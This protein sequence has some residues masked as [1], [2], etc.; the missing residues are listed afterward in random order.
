MVRLLLVEDNKGIAG[1]VRS[2]LSEFGFAVDLAGS[3]REFKEY[4]RATDYDVIVL[5]LGLPDGDGITVLR[6]F[7]G[8]SNRAA[9]LILTARNDVE[10]RIEGLR[11]GAD[12]YLG[13][14]FSLEELKARV[15]ALSRRPRQF[16]NDSLTYGNV[17]FDRRT[18]NVTVDS[19][20]VPLSRAESDLLEQLLLSP[21]TT[22]TREALENALFSWDREF[23]DNA[24]QLQVHRL[25]KTLALAGADIFVETL[26]GVG[27][28]LRGA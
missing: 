3:L 25:R 18:R 15:L 11:Q 10:S 20:L 17:A 2:A 19:L 23:S 16:I 4:A 7:R 14:P 9:I 24:L 5:D 6:E 22:C 26:R 28:R 13:K 27:Y 1:P 12:D 8:N 21:G